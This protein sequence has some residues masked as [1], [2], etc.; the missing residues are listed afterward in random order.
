MTVAL[1]FVVLFGFFCC[2]FLGV[3]IVT[4]V[5]RLPKLHRAVW[6]RDLNKTKK[7]TKNIKEKELNRQDEEGLRSGFALVHI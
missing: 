4:N 2:C 5:K 7:R 1:C 6:K 3:Y